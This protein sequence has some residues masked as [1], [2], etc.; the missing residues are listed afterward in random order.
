MHTYHTCRRGSSACT[1][2][3]SLDSGHCYCHWL[4]CPLGG[5]V[6]LPKFKAANWLLSVPWLGRQ[7]P[8]VEGGG[9]LTGSFKVSRCVCVCA[10]V[11]ACVRACVCKGCH[12][13]TVGQSATVVQVLTAKN[14]ILI[15]DLL[16]KFT[17]DR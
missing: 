2:T 3:R 4:S 13:H 10:C 7:T 17:L 16:L 1:G 15:L 14:L 5:S 8:P 6:T 12:T 11:R 9:C